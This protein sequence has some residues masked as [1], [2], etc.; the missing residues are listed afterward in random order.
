MRS[1]IDAV[2]GKRPSKRYAISVFDVPSSSGMET[3][4]V[5]SSSWRDGGA[6]AGLELSTRWVG[7]SSF[8]K[9]SA[10]DP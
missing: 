9:G 10:L 6:G 7:K 1:K 4:F 5:S 3:P 8:A 2:K